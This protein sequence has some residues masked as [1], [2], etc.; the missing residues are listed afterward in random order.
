MSGTNQSVLNAFYENMTYAKLC[1]E[2]EDYEMLE[3]IFKY[4]TY[5]LDRALTLADFC[6][7]VTDFADKMDTLSLVTSMQWYRDKVT[8]TDPEVN[9]VTMFLDKLWET[10]DALE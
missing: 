10:K 7:K 5:D 1:R 2:P 3:L 9:R 8:S 4:K 6:W